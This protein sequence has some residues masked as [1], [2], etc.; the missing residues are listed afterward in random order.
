[1][2]VALAVV[3]PFLIARGGEPDPADKASAV[4]RIAVL[5]FEDLS[6][7][8][9]LG[10]LASGFTESLIDALSNVRGL[11]VRSKSAV[12]YY[13]LQD[14]P[15]DSLARALGVNLLID[16][17]LERSDHEL[18]VRVQLIDGA[19]GRVLESRDVHRSWG[20]A[21]E[22]RD[23]VVSDVA[24]LLRRRMRQE[25]DFM[26]RRTETESPHAWEAFQRAQRVFDNFVPLLSVNG[27]EA[28][29][30]T[31]LTADSLLITAEKQDEGWVAPIVLR[32]RLAMLKS[33]VAVQRGG[34][35]ASERIRNSLDEA[36]GH[37]NRALAADPDNAEALEFRGTVRY[38]LRLSGVI[39]DSREY[40][41]AAR[42][43]ETDLRKAVT[44]D[45][46]RAQA[47]AMLGR[48]KWN[49]GQFAEAYNASLNSYNADRYYEGT[50]ESVS[51]LAM[52]AYEI[53]RDQEAVSWC[54]EGRRRFPTHD[55][56]IYCRI[57]LMAVSDVVPVEL[58]TV[59]ALGQHAPTHVP[60]AQK[61]I[62]SMMYRLLGAAAATRLGNRDS[63]AIV[64]EDA[65]RARISDPSFLWI[66]AI[67]RLRLGQ[68][69]T[70]QKLLLAYQ[71]AEPFRSLPILKS[72]VFARLTPR[73]S[74]D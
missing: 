14:I 6:P 71:R 47:W 33:L 62:V 21:L 4:P 8:H 55:Q 18:R 36:L 16:G 22:M 13:D 25:F 56:F 34:A 27:V 67:A 35:R 20:P 15:Q 53:G 48:I 26:I 63:L 3:L 61:A 74:P 23:S 38:R 72:R 37:A 73:V 45:S 5:P 2:V 24:V 54:N 46:L 70:A 17:S 12:E 43:A 11:E 58:D 51:T 68:D 44:V 1:M 7:N 29:E 32:G 66:E 57:A 65:K 60:P 69:S 52:A 19:T 39:R 28:A 9:E 59:F 41:S 31:L 50:V 10:Y 42:E 49:T 40:E 30:R 64:L